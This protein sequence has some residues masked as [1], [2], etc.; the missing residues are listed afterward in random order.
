LW[1]LARRG[2]RRAS[3]R[4]FSVTV[5]G[6][7][8]QVQVPHPQGLSYQI[9]VD[10]QPV[11]VQLAPLGKETTGPSTANTRLF[12]IQAGGRWLRVEVADEPG[13]K[14]RVLID[15]KPLEVTLGPA[16]PVASAPQQ[17]RAAV[18][19]P[20]RAAR[21]AAD[22]SEKQVTAAMPGRIV[23]VSVRVGQQVAE[24]QELCVLEAMKMEQIIRA[25]SPGVVKAIRI[26]PGQTVAAG[27]LLVELE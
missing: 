21:A 5:A 13:R 18:A 24:G 6:R 17:P 8:R 20:S 4:R 23:A 27:D 12:R 3:G 16:G 19:R 14:P 15:G 2:L 22:G 10:G 1:E 11:T 25:A 9:L 26:K 7:R